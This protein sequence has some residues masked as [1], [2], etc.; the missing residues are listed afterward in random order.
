M[1]PSTEKAP[2][3]YSTYIGRV[4][5]LAIFLG[6]GTS[7]G[8]ATATADTDAAPP[9]R[10]SASASVSSSS[11]SASGPS[12]RGLRVSARSAADGPRPSS[13]SAQPAT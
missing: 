1:R 6:V 4:G 9:S 11:A 7:L 13:R 2:I 3:G 8:M 10:A 12:A 5:A